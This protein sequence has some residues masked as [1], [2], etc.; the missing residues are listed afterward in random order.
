[1]RS[2]LLAALV[3]WVALNPLRGGVGPQ[4]SRT[5]PDD[6]PGALLRR[7]E[8]ALTAGNRE[9]YLD[10]VSATA[11]LSQARQFATEAFPPG[12]TRAVVRERDRGPLKGTPEGNGY[13]LLVEVLVETGA[14]ARLSTWRLDV[15]RQSGA[16]NGQPGGSWGIVGQESLTTLAGL[17]RLSLNPRRQF[18]ANDVTIAA[19]DFQ[20]TMRTGS[21]FA[22]ETVDGP[23]AVVLIGTGEMTFRPAPA[24]E[25]DQVKIFCGSETLQTPFEVAFLR[26]SP[27]DLDRYVVHG[28]LV[29]RPVDQRD[30]KRADEVFDEELP[31]SFGLDL[32]DLSPDPWSLAPA[33]GDFLADVRTRR[34]ETLTYA[35]SHS[36]P[37]DIS[38]FDRKRHRNISIYG[39][40]EKL[41]TQGRFYDEDNLADY[42]VLDYNLDVAFIPNRLWVNGR[43]RMEIVTKA[44]SMAALTLRLAESLSVRAVVSNELGRLLAIRVRNQNSV[45]VNLPSTVTRG[46]KLTLTVLYNGRLEPQSIDR[47]IV[48]LDPIRQEVQEERVALPTEER[49]LYSNRSYWYPETP[50]ANYATAVLRLRVP[51]DYSCVASGDL[52]SNA[53]EPGDIASSGSSKGQEAAPRVF[54]FRTGRPVR[55]LS[56]LITHLVRAS[57]EDVQAAAVARGDDASRVDGGGYRVLN[58]RVEANPRQRG[59]GRQVAERAAGILRFYSSLIG[60]FPYPSLTCAIIENDLPG[61]HSPAYLAILNQQLPGSQL[62]WRDDPASFPGYPDF[63]LAHEI[64]HQ[65]WGQ[66]VGW[67]NYHEQWLSEG[68]AQYFA[69]LNAERVRGPEVFNQSIRQARGWAVKDSN[70]GAVYLGYRV[71]HIKRDGRIFRA[72]VYNKS[73]A[74]L[75]MLR[76]LIGDEAFFRGI[77]RFYRTWRYHKAGTEDLR[78]A[79]E[80]ES[81]ISLERFFERWIYNAS[82]PDV[83]F[84]SRTE[85]SPT[86]PEVVLRFEQSG[87]IFDFP[88]TVTLFYVDGRTTDILMKVTDRVVETRMPLKGRLNRVEVNRDEATVAEFPG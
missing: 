26:L 2:S 37:E 78:R 51:A 71:G 35:R 76:R 80:A 16:P 9:G 18:T 23:T 36:E 60:D 65:W 52:I 42:E 86:G 55:Y 20:L 88:V 10:L 54:L 59:R 8:E 79:F 49:Y 62:V 40:R 34:F 28:A 83:K 87:E 5:L 73:A 38:L 85:M 4:P 64:A 53:A 70:Q 14:R 77:R 69:L 13:S 68:L 48:A 19:E 30:L 22:A 29:E 11:N 82:L 12:V 33:S 50:A 84:S 17:Y 67:K 31:K 45:V 41:A 74:V 32:S 7:I 56:C 24:A 75:Q 6:G 72:V 1:M 57:N 3:V 44:P 15:T 43:A 25:R 39:S 63:F 61:G 46:M 47:E 58:L 21:A 27:G 81:G 66:A